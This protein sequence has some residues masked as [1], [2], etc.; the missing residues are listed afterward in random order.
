MS[1]FA[2]FLI[3]G[4]LTFIPSAFAD[5]IY[6]DI[7]QVSDR[8]FPMAI[9]PPTRDSGEVD[10]ESGAIFVKVLRD[11][12]ERV[13]VFRFIEPSAFLES[14]SKPA[15]KEKDIDFASWAVLDTLALIKGWYRRS[16]G[17]ITIEPHLFDVLLKKEISAK[18]YEGTLEQI[19]WMAHRFANEVMRVLTGQEGVFD[20][21]IAFI[22]V[23]DRNKELHVMDFNGDHLERLTF[24]KSIVL[25]PTWAANGNDIYYTSF[26]GGKTP[27]LFKYDLKRKSATRITKF[28]GMVIGSTLDP[29]GDLLATTLTMDGNSEIYLLDLDGKIR[30]RLTKNADIDVSPSFSP[31]GKQITFVSNRDGSPQIY[32]MG[33]DGGNVQRLTFKGMN[34]TAPAWSP[35]GDKILFAG[36]D[37]DGEFDVFSMNVDGSGIVRL[38]Y[39]TRNNEEPKWSP[40]GSMILFKS[41]RTGQNQLFTMRLDGSHPVQLTRDSWDHSMPAW[42][43]KPK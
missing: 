35:K 37:T 41:N 33:R 3:L 11:D 13:G 6:I 40:D 12:L 31:D 1:R 28:P 29:S 27:Q 9:V 24:D 36:M 20:T 16:G 22:G 39:D 2:V 14:P 19:P 23:R 32:K 17:R 26:A 43:P 5:K 25:S 8:S 21:R 10:N 34:N 42:G 30:N 18:H 38:T 4:F 7:T 15:Y